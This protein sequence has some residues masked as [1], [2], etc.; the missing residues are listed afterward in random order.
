MMNRLRPPR[1][2][3]LAALP[4][5]CAPPAGLA[6]VRHDYPS[7]LTLAGAVEIALRENPALAVARSQLDISEQ[8]ILQ[9]RSGILPR[10]AVSES[11]ART[12]NPPQVFSY[13]LGQENFGASDFAIDR[14]NE[15]DAISN[16][17]TNLSTV[18]PLYDGGRS[19]HGWQQ[20]KL[21][22][23][24]ATLALEGARQ[25]V[26]AGTTAAY[27]GA[28][29]AR[30]RLAVVDSA[31]ATARAHLA[32]VSSRT[33]AGLTVKSDLLQAQVRLADLEQQ[34]IEA[35]SH[36]SNAHAALNTAMG[37]AHDQTFELIDELTAG[38]EPGGSL[39]DWI[40]TALDRRPDI[41]ELALRDAMAEEEVAKSRAAHLPSLDLVG[42]Y[43]VNTEDFD[44]SADNY[45]VGAVVSLNLFGGFGPSAQVA[46]AEAA[47]RRVHAMRRQSGSRA[48]LETRQAYSRAQSAFQR[49]AV[50][51]QAV[52][53]AAEAVRIVGDRYETGLVTIVELLGSEAALQ[54]ARSLHAQAVHDSIVAEANLRLAAGVLGE[55]GGSGVEG[56]RVQ[57][58]E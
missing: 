54:Q 7:A 35:E 14:L 12:N 32:L 11:F 17:A 28:L 57:G 22:R 10:L 58:S 30:E 25:A 4:I 16:F 45:S 20:A 13:K 42:N 2:L 36:L 38:R 47:R 8:R 9:A 23:N 37:V 19:W 50:T 5:L 21:G 41:R 44:N 26:I 31:L 53:Q 51:R 40:A 56:P 55:T 39:E 3:W 15:P 34:R 27:A 24:A 52:A 46:E 48:T 1:W 6:Q 43:Q 18:W 33:A 49:V 29:L